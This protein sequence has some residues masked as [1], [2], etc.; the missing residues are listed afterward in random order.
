MY[1]TGYRTLLYGFGEFHLAFLEYKADNKYLLEREARC[2][3]ACLSLLANQNPIHLNV[4]RPIEG[5]SDGSLQ[6]KP[7]RDCNN[8]SLLYCSKTQATT[9]LC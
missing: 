9:K 2:Y 1:S 8:Y 7:H 4:V 3:V 5:A 6:W